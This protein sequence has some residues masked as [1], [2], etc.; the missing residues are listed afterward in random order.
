MRRF[1]DEAF[2]QRGIELDFTGPDAADSGKLDLELRRELLLIFKEAL[3]TLCDTPAV[4]RG[5]RPASAGSPP[6]LTVADNGAGFDTTNE[7]EG[8]GLTSMQRRGDRLKGKLDIRSE[9]GGG[10]T[11]LIAIPTCSRQTLQAGLPEY[12]GD[13]VRRTLRRTVD[14]YPRLLHVQQR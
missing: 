10:T 3:T 14:G 4:A 12:G 8:H 6:A 9:T 1:A 5:G 7:S 2:A 13:L 11:V